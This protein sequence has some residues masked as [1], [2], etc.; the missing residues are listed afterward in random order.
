M[1]EDDL[2][3]VYVLKRIARDLIINLS[4]L[5]DDLLDSFKDL[6]SDILA[7]TVSAS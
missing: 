1:G 7:G 4:Q 6:C 2:I 3:R 5:I